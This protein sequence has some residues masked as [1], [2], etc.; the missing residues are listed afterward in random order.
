[1]AGRAAAFTN[2]LPVV[3]PLLHTYCGLNAPNLPFQ[4]KI[5]SCNECIHWH[6][7]I[8]LT[9]AQRQSR[10]QKPPCFKKDDD[11][12]LILSV[13]NRSKHQIPSLMAHAFSSYYTKIYGSDQ[14]KIRIETFMKAS[15]WRG[16][17]WINIQ[18]SRQEI[19]LSDIAIPVL[20][21]T[22]HSGHS[23]REFFQQWVKP[24]PHCRQWECAMDFIGAGTASQKLRLEP[25]QSLKKP[26]LL[27]LRYLITPWLK[28]PPRCCFAFN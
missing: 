27:Q 22:Q 26:N 16:G 9:A 28:N 18:N 2:T 13:S 25:R 7:A 4:S 6:G 17:G 10:E 1:M 3:L 20:A 14:V 23:G 8:K 19:C 24:W 11:V 15:M 21:P 12:V 5:K